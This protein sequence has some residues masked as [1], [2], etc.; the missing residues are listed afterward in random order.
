MT[1]TPTTNSTVKAGALANVAP[2]FKRLVIVGALA[3]FAISQTACQ[4]VD[5]LRQDVA[6]K[7]TC[8][9]YSQPSPY[10]LPSIQEGSGKE[11]GCDSIRDL[12]SGK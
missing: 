3:L 5:T 12:V 7:I 8:G 1:H 9:D 4:K 6:G 11:T 10:S 2:N